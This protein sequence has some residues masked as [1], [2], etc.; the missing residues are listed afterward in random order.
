MKCFAAFEK[1]FHHAGRAAGTIVRAANSH[2]HS[3]QNHHRY[4]GL[5]ARA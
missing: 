2:H 1:K 5:W 4:G 3:F